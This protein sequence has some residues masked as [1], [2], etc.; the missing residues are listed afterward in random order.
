MFFAERAER[1]EFVKP[2][3]HLMRGVKLHEISPTYLEKFKM[4]IYALVFQNFFDVD[5]HIA[6]KVAE[7]PPRA[8]IFTP[9]ISTEN[10]WRG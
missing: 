2:I 10:C 4:V 1:S 3:C 8:L 6:P 7:I 9:D 5:F